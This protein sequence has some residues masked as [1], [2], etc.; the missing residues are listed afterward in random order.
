LGGLGGGVL[1]GG[2][3]GGGVLA[4][5]EVLAGGALDVVPGVISI[6]LAALVADFR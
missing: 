3:L 5:G 1:A 4:G 6:V 2:A